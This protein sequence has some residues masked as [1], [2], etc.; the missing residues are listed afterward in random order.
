MFRLILR[1]KHKL[2]MKNVKATDTNF[3]HIYQA[4]NL[5]ALIELKTPNQKCECLSPN[6]QLSKT[7]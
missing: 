1:N 4:R 6:L 2:N 7:P 5:F 3:D